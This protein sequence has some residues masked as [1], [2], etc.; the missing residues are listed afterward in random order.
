M[1]D[2]GQSLASSR[3]ACHIGRIACNNIWYADDLCL[4]APSIAA[5]QKLINFCYDYAEAHNIAFN[6][7]KT[8]CMRFC[9]GKDYSEPV[10]TVNSVKIGWVDA[11]DYLGFKI[12]NASKNCD[13]AEIERRLRDMRV[14]ANMLDARFSKASEYVHLQLF[15]TFFNQVYCLGLWVVGTK[16]YEQKAKVTLNNCFRRV[17]NKWGIFSVSHEFVIRG[18]QTWGEIRRSA[19]YSLY[20]RI[21][22]SDNEIVSAICNCATFTINPILCEMIRILM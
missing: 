21:I 14:R 7:S 1:N 15:R 12:S 19:S 6:A 17:F 11:F 2:L 10:F 16:K 20:T 4:L 13:A 22:Q 3:H 18:L 9:V 8:V 5:L